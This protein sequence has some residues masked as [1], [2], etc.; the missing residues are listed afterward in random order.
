MELNKFFFIKKVITKY[1]KQHNADKTITAQTLYNL[2]NEAE[3]EFN[4]AQNNLNEI[5]E[6]SKN[7]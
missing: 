2:I 4:S 7:I 6:H 5:I 3:Q 1:I